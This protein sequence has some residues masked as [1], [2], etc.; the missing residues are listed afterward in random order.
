MCAKD[1]L[2]RPKADVIICICIFMYDCKKK[3]RRL[4]LFTTQNNCT[5]D[6]VA[7][8]IISKQLSH[9]EVV[10]IITIVV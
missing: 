3:E 4:I 2:L 9:F 8:L 10:C 6:C 7:S 1:H 5:I